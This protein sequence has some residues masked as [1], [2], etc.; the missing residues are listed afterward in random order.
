M[1]IKTNVTIDIA[2][3]PEKV[4]EGLT[5]RERVAQ[6]AGAD[7][8]YLP[9]DGSELHVGYTAKGTRTGPSGPVETDYQVTACEPPTL[10]TSCMH[11]AGGEAIETYT[12]AATATGTQLGVS[13]DTNYAQMEMT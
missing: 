4:F 8:D 9:Q 6:W 11:Y 1:G 3:P 12:L 10:L 2:A 5:S 13:A 7:P